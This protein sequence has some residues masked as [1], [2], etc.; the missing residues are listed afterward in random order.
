MTKLVKIGNSQG[1]KIPKDLIKLAN[2]SGEIEFELKENGLLLKPAN[3]R[4]G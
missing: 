4:S 2:L 3:P 1:V